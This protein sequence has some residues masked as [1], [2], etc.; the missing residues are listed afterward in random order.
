MVWKMQTW[1]RIVPSLSEGGEKRTFAQTVDYQGARPE[2]RFF[3]VGA[4]EPSSQKPK[5]KSF[6]EVTDSA[7]KLEWET[8]GKTRSE[9]DGG[10]G[11]LG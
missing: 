7:A 9:G 4:K 8:V 11:T 6:S 5:K 1:G 2:I 10:W 3:Q